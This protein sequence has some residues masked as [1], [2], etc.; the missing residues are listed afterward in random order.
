MSMRCTATPSHVFAPNNAP[1]EQ[2]YFRYPTAGIGRAARVAVGKT[3]TGNLLLLRTFGPTMTIYEREGMVPHRSSMAIW[4]EKPRSS[5][6]SPPPAPNRL[7][8][9]TSMFQNSRATRHELEPLERVP[10]ESDPGSGW[11][12]E[13][14]FFRKLWARTA[15]VVSFRAHPCRKFRSSTWGKCS[16]SKEISSAFSPRYRRIGRFSG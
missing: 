8:P 7:P 15:W 14:F 13:G 6:R 4:F 9:Y 16:S 12:P 1:N 11:P 3:G 2:A 5:P 10:S